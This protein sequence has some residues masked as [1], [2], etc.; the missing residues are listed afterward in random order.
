MEDFGSVIRQ[1]APAK[2]NWDNLYSIVF[3]EII[4]CDFDFRE[5][6]TFEAGVRNE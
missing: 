1:L 2:D 5:P 3:R 4:N 6:H